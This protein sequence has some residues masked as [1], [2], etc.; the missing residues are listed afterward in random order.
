MLELYLHVIRKNVDKFKS[1]DP[2]VTAH[3]ANI[4]TVL[5]V[6]NTNPI[7]GTL[8][9]SLFFASAVQ[10]VKPDGS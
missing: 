4:F 1:R 7:G 6:R 2:L 5:A 3:H 8:C 9:Q 10:I